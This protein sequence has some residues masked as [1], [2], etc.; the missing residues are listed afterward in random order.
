MANLIIIKDSYLNYD[1][2]ENVV[3][4]VINTDATHGVY[5]GYGVL[6]DDPYYYMDKLRTRYRNTGKQVQHFVLSFDK[7][8]NQICTY[9][10][11]EIGYRICVLFSSYQSVFGFH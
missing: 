4:Y 6:L 3:N 10:I 5:G 8:D 9:D 2:L 11:Y 7:Q 1:A